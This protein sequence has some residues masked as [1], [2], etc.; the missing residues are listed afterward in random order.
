MPE[1]GV[2]TYGARNQSGKTHAS[3]RLRELT[4]RFIVFDFNSELAEHFYI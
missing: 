2:R 4:N 1:K 3:D